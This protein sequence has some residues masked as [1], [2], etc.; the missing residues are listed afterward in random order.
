MPESPILGWPEYMELLAGLLALV[1]PISSVPIFLSLTRAHSPRHRARIAA[2]AAMSAGIVLLVALFL[3]EIV[4]HAFGIGIDS[5]RVAGGIL[6]LLIALSMM[7]SSTQGGAAAKGAEESVAVDEGTALGVVPLAI[8]IL[9][10]PGAM[11]TV[12]VY[13]HRATSPMHYVLI[14][15]AI[16]SLS[17]LIYL[18]YRFAP[19]IGRLL[20]TTGMNVLSRV[21]GL[22]IAAV[23]IEFIVDGLSALFPGLAH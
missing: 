15:A 6:I 17:A 18:S 4:L 7:Q 2:V 19:A 22:I 14:T 3:G 11:S 5:F 12:I 10:G 21:M 9:V 8:P 16:V 20:G 1:N 23:A 13:A